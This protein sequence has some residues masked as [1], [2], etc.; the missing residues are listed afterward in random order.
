M[1]QRDVGL[2]RTATLNRSVV[3]FSILALHSAWISAAHAQDDLAAAREHFTKG[4]RA[5]DLGQYSEAAKEYEAAYKAKDDPALLFNIGQAYR[6]LGDNVAALRA[7]KGYLR[8]VP[9][10][11]NRAVVESR[12]AE[13]TRVIQEHRDQGGKAPTVPTPAEPST[14]AAAK[15]APKTT[16]AATMA[17]SNALAQ[18]AP[19]QPQ[20]RTPR[21]WIWGLVAGVA[22]AGVAVGLGVG[23]GTQPHHPIASDGTVTFP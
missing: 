15:P 20:K 5:F 3:F 11:P 13:L 12:I 17:T 4:T 19:A 22:V 14:T 9:D 18:T 16:P 8:R 1:Y 6:Q 21:A 23:L 10:A 7:Y 2:A